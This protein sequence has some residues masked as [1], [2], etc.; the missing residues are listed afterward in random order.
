MT[1]QHS[2]VNDK[3]KQHKGDSNRCV[4]GTAHLIGDCFY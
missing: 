4:M 1:F 3:E 2:T